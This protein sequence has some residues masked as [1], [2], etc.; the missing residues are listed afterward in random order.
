MMKVRHFPTFKLRF[1]LIELLVVIAII[2]I[3]ASLLLPS[4]SKAR[5][6]ARQI[7][8]QNNLKQWGLYMALY[9]DENDAWTPYNGYPDSW[10]M[11][12]TSVMGKSI[13]SWGLGHR[14]YGVWQ[15]PENILQ[16]HPAHYA[17]G[18]WFNSYQPNGR[19]SAVMY[20][21]NKSTRFVYPTQ[22]VGMLEG[23]YYV[24]T[25]WY[26]DG[27]GSVPNL[28]SG[29]QY[30][31]YPHNLQVNLMYADGHV[32]AEDGPLPYRGA[33]TGGSGPDAYKNGRM[34]IGY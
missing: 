34:W 7:S 26:N 23:T 33:F 31:R 28:A 6:K 19:L 4:L 12:I 13:D 27:L 30:A 20:M 21:G 29:I 17:A 15:C 10:F 25:P 14:N 8:C 22:L 11:N 9:T 2:A 32:G 16:I 1:T 3:L 18:E 5:G 24:N